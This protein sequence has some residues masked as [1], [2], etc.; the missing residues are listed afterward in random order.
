MSK[1]IRQQFYLLLYIS[2]NLQMIR[3]D[4]ITNFKNKVS[5]SLDCNELQKVKNDF[6]I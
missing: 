3:S 6:V 5:V 2:T 1:K 4:T